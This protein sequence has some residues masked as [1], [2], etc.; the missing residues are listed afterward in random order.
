MTAFLCLTQIK[1]DQNMILNVHSQAISRHADVLL[2]LFVASNFCDYCQVLGDANNVI[3]T[4]AIFRQRL[5][6][7][8]EEIFYNKWE[9]S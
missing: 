1:A 2:V 5:V 3:P 7:H 4:F 6:C 8:H 9:C